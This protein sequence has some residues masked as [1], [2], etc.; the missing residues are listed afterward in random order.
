MILSETVGAC[1]QLGQNVLA[2]GPTDIEG[3]TQ[4]LYA[5]LTMS[6]DERHRRAMALKKSIAEEDV[7]NWLWRLLDDIARLVEQR[8]E[9][10]T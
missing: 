2:V 1:E 3:T 10:T 7:T 5:A 4:A 9:T 6:A 8:S